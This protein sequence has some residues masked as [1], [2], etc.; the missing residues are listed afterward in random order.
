MEI[1]ICPMAQDLIDI[2]S[3]SKRVAA[4]EEMTQGEACHFVT[5]AIADCGEVVELYRTDKPGI[6]NYIGEINGNDDQSHVLGALWMPFKSKWWES[7]SGVT[8]IQE[9]WGC[10]PDCVAIRWSDAEIL[11][12]ISRPDQARQ[13][14]SPTVVPRRRKHHLEHAFKHAANRCSDSTDIGSVWATLVDMAKAKS[15]GM[16]GATENGIQYLDTN[17]APRNFSKK[18]LKAYIEGSNLNRKR[19]RKSAQ[20]ANNDKIT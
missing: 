17:D 18:Q 19:P 16:F 11:L 7:P 1:A 15:H 2:V 12:D 10:T 4:P 14:E 3:L 6:P 20:V 8:K 9:E 13:V 5:L